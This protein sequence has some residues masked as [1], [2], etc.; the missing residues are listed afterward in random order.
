MKGRTKGR[1]FLTTEES[2]VLAA[3]IS[4]PNELTALFLPAEVLGSALRESGDFQARLIDEEGR[5]AVS[6]LLIG[7]VQ[8]FLSAE[9]RAIHV[10]YETDVII[11]LGLRLNIP[12]LIAFLA[13]MV[14]SVSL[15]LFLR[16][17][18]IGKAIRAVSQ[19]RNAAWLMGINVKRMSIIAFGLGSALAGTAGALISPTYYIF[20]QVGSTFTLKAFV[21]TVL[22]GMGSIVGA[23]LGGILIGIAESIGYF[24]GVLDATR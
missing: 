21:I 1:R 7:L 14:I 6:T 8:F 19:S 9:S 11:V 2:V 4:S 22:G 17:T 24:R 13:S 16:F 10:P 15:Y 23:T 18:R 3:W 20:P 5:L 12:R